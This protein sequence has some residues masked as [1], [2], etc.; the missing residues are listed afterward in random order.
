MK[1][2]RKKQNN[3]A[4]VRE[5]FLKIIAVLVIVGLNWTGL[6]AI[7][8]TFAYMNDTENSPENIF[9][10]STLDFS[11]NAGEWNPKQSEASLEWGN[12]AFKDVDVIDEGILAFQYTAETDN[13]AGDI[14]FCN[15]LNLTAELEG[16][17]VYSGSLTGFLPSATTTLDS[18]NFRIDMPTN[19]QNS[20]CNFDFLYNGWQTDVA[21]YNEGGFSDTEKTENTISSWGLR[22][23][24]VYYD[25]A[26]DKGVEGD[27]EWVEIYNQTNTALDI[28]GWEIC[29]NN[30]CDSIPSSSVISSEDFAVISASNSTWGYWEIPS[31]VVKIVLSDAEIGNGLHNDADMLILKRP[32]GVI[33]D[34]MNWGNPDT[35]WNNYNENVWNPGAI[36]VAE[37]NM[38]GRNPNGYDTNE[39]SDFIEFGPPIV[40]LIYPDQSGTLIWYWYQNYNIQWT[41]VNPN[42]NDADLSIDLY[43]IKDINHD[44]IISNGDTIHT[45]VK[46]TA[47]DGLYTWKV[48]GGFIGYIWTKIVVKGPENP[49]LNDSMTSGKIFDPF[50]L[51]LWETNPEL[52]MAAFAEYE[53]NSGESVPEEFLMGL[54]LEETVAEEPAVAVETPV[55]EVIELEEIT[56]PEEENII[57]EPVTE[58]EI[59]A[60]ENSTTTEETSTN[61]ENQEGGIIGQINEIINNIVNEIIEEIMPSESTNESL[62]NPLNAETQ[63][64]EEEIQIGEE[65]P[66]IEQAPAESLIIETPPTIEE[67]P[68]V[69]EETPPT[70]EETPPAIE[71]TPPVIEQEPVQEEPAPPD[72]TPSPDGDSQNADQ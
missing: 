59:I 14:D 58:E 12:T 42:G 18:W 63:P 3:F 35:A 36:D 21:N 46:N 52:I 44:K 26:N 28:S 32:D 55:E 24:K 1:L 13:E 57:E 71:E 64:S 16:L 15:S 5:S 9:Q 11:L 4:V 68:S 48:P 30:S 60:N 31:E 43:Y 23:N 29:D 54:N 70:I 40:N 8:E 53:T 25:V 50:P 41:A 2:K 49:M 37:G 65:Q 69:I 56:E 45:I 17:E 33:I 72:P 22:I 51:E 19:Y 38:L 61:T 10:A 66:I 39:A 34:Q 47:N 6:S 20:I 27:N 62:E 67:I 7:I